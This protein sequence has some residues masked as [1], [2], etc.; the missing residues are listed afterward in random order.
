MFNGKDV[1]AKIIMQCN[2]AKS[3]NVCCFAHHLK[4]FRLFFGLNFICRFCVRVECFVGS[5]FGG[6]VKDPFVLF[7]DVFVGGE[8][9]EL[10]V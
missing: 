10:M 6:H 8:N 5:R 1:L 7:N 4:M 2:A 9:I 3:E